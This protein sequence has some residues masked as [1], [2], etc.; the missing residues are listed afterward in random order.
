[1]KTF[2]VS[3]LSCLLLYS[4][5]LFAQQ[6]ITGTVK[7]G[8]GETLIGVSIQEKGKTNGAQTD[9]DG[10]YSLTVSGPDAVL[11]FTYVG[12]IKQEVAV[13]NRQAVD[14]ILKNDA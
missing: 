2:Y 8:Q 6:K 13:G 5:N 11:V 10:H 7:D 12:F 3:L 1:M 14:V 4:T 9:I